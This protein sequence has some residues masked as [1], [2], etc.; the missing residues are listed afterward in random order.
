MINIT[1]DKTM[2][3]TPIFVSCILVIVSAHTTPLPPC[4]GS[5]ATPGAFSSIAQNQLIFVFTTPE[6]LRSFIDQG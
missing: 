5:R 1:S 4:G 3:A 6:A 2:P